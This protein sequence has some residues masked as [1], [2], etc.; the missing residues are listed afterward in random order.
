MNSPI[1]VGVLNTAQAIGDPDAAEFFRGLTL[2]WL[3]Y[4]YDGVIT[5]SSSPDELVAAALESQARYGFLVPYGFIVSEQW[6]V[7]DGEAMDFFHALQVWC[8]SHD[9]HVVGQ[10]DSNCFETSCVLVDLAHHR[11]QGCPALHSLPRTPWDSDLAASLLDLGAMSPTARQALSNYRGNRVAN[12]LP[13]DEALSG[14]QRRFLQ[15]V[16]KQAMH[17]RN[18]VFLWNIEP[19]DDIET[20]AKGFPDS[21]S[22]LY[23]VAAGFKPNRILE[24]HRFTEQSKVVYLDYSQA[25]LDVKKFMIEHWDGH[26]FPAFVYRLFEVF[27]HPETF[28]QLWDDVT[29]ETV[30]PQDI[31]RVWQRELDRWDSAERF[32]EHW[33][34]YRTLEHQF[35]PCDL[36]SDI[37][38]LLEPMQSEASA[39]IWWSNAFFTMYGNWRCDGEYRQASYE[40]WIQGL[41]ERNPALYLVGSDFNNTCV[42]DVQAAEYWNDYCQADVDYLHP[43]KRHRTTIRM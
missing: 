31:Q 3:R 32:R 18:G 17:A 33:Q 21:I 9:F 36:L 1:A 15:V 25:A 23:S 40:R 27:P 28:Y 20:P 5:E 16:S 22:T 10:S 11:N 24:T 34:R 38:P 43:Y 35:V 42:N 26:D 29:P 30:A 6:R 19:Y 2:S 8:D 7:R 37:G 14:D 4:G 39:V 41:A 13:G 12:F